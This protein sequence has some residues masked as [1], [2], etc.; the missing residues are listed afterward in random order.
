MIM[1]VNK[2]IKDD[3]IAM[4]MLGDTGLAIVWIIDGDCL[5]DIPV[6]SE[7]VDMFLL[8]DVVDEVSH[9]Y[10]DHEGIAVRFTKNNQIVN[11]LLTSEYF[12]SILLS[13]PLI[14]KIEDY[15]YGM[16]L[17]SPYGKFDGE[18]FIIL[19]QDVTNLIPWPSKMEK[20]EE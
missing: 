10:P 14:L 16:Y 2:I 7:Y 5:Y 4:N 11:D 6:K 8:S 20:N 18:K 13:S 3:D 9:L 15:A 19:D 12:G 1:G 17:R